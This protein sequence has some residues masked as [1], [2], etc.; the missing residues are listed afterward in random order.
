MTA[1]LFDCLGD[2]SKLK[3]Q[4]L[5]SNT[6][7][8]VDNKVVPC[9]LRL[10]K[11]VKPISEINKDTHQR[12]HLSHYWI[13]LEL[14]KKSL[15]IYNHLYTYTDPDNKYTNLTIRIHVTNSKYLIYT[16]G[17]YLRKN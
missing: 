5:N 15:E 1:S 2:K 8:D 11:Y 9:I 4:L 16:S 12:T 7:I 10:I 3:T 17:I 14:N 13:Q 6:D